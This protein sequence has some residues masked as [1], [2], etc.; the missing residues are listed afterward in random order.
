[1]NPANLTKARDLIIAELSRFVETGPTRLELQD[2]QS[3]FVGRL[4]L[5]LESNAGVCGALLNTERYG[6]GLDYYQRYASL[7]RNTRR[8]DVIA[9]VRRWIDPD[10]LVV[11]SAGP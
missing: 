3:N 5:S 11:A 1:V 6:L 4:P 8:A 7:V 9:C 10:R 2:S